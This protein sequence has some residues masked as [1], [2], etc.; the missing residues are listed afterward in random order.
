MR[1]QLKL[2]PPGRAG[3]LRVQ[4]KT[5]QAA[6]DEAGDTNPFVRRDGKTGDRDVVTAAYQQYVV[7][8][9]ARWLDAFVAAAVPLL[10]RLRG[11]YQEQRK[12]VGDIQCRLDDVNTRVRDPLKLGVTAWRR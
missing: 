6:R 12:V 5:L 8:V 1:K 7:E 10:T 4:Q 3:R 2:D 11:E 9:L